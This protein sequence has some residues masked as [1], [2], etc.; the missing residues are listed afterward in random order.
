MDARKVLI[1]DTTLRD[2]EKVPGLVLSLNEKVR[3][4]K[5]IVKLDVDVLEVGFPGASEGEFEAAK[6]IVA[7]VSGPKLVCLA[8]PTSKKDFEAA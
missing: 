6:E 8:R 5:Q 3:I 7:T 2:G 1:F 4:A